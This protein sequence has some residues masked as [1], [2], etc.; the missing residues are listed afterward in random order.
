MATPFLPP[1]PLVFTGHDC[2][3]YHREQAYVQAALKNSLSL[4]LA[5]TI[6]LH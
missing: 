1:Y 5:A 4:L 3:I 2:S 6:I